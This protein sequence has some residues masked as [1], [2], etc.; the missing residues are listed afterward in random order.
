MGTFYVYISREVITMPRMARLLLKNYCYHII[1]RGNQ[2]QNVFLDEVDFRM[3]LK[4]LMKYTK[5]FK[6]RLYSFCLM[7]NHIHL[8][9][10]PDDPEKLRKLMQGLNLSYAIY[11][12]HKYNKVGHL[13]QDRFLSK[14]IAKDGYLLDCISYIEA[15]PVRANIA[16]SAQDYKWSSYNLRLRQDY[17]IITKIEIL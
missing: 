13:W 6:T 15:N 16:T 10:E 17:S 5:R 7:P 2:K 12:N 8:L 1:T 3:Y 14:I 9:L 11:F 4:A